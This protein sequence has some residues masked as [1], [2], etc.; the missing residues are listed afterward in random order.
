MHLFYLLDTYISL[1]YTNID[2]QYSRYR[3]YK[4]EDTMLALGEHKFIYAS[5]FSI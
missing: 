2:I 1:S 4:S 5:V 3:W